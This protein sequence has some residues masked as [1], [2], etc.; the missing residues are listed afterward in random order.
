MFNSSLD[1][2]RLNL[3]EVASPR[4]DLISS[5]QIANGISTVHAIALTL[6]HCGEIQQVQIQIAMQ[7]LRKFLEFFF[8]NQHRG[9]RCE[10]HIVQKHYLNL[11]QT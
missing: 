3:I 10:I 9:L 6:N 7:G 11:M 2:S 1:S 5:S 4:F 8:Y